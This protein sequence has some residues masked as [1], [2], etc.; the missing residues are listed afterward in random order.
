MLEFK[1]KILL[2]I[3]KCA[4]T[5]ILTALNLD[6]WNGD[7]AYN[8]NYDVK[9][10]YDDFHQT[11]IPASRVFTSKTKYAFVRN[12]WDRTVS[13]YY[14]CKKRYKITESFEDFVKNKIIKVSYDFGPPSWRQQIDWIDSNTICMRVED[15]VQKQL[16]EYFDVDVTIPT[17]NS[18]K[19]LDYSSL[20]TQELYDLVAEYYKDDIKKFNYS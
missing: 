19:I 5:S 17:V 10:V 12:P 1:D 18:M 20:Y 8:E 16:K 14:Y 11:H 4:G 15:G 13:R 9:I 3:P 2:H 6:V 7:D